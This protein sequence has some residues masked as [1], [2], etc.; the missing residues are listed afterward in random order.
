[1]IKVRIGPD[2]SLKYETVGFQGSACLSKGDEF[3]NKMGGIQAD[4]QY[5]EEMYNEDQTECGRV[6][7][8]V[9]E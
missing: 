6:D 1:M 4:T 9:S 7:V 8:H 5:T 2:G 3:A